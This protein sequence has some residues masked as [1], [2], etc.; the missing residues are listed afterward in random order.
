L[1]YFK[2]KLII[3]SSKK[4]KSAS[5]TVL[6]LTFTLFTPKKLFFFRFF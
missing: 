2:K 1:E 6:K 5:R 3:F 4:K